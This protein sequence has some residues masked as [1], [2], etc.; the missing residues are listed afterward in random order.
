MTWREYKKKVKKI[1]GRDNCKFR[2]KDGKYYLATRI[3]G[4]L[5]YASNH[6]MWLDFKQC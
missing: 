3:S 2:K 5:T 1:C 6:W 4:A